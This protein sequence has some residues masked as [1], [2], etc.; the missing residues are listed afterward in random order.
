[1]GNLCCSDRDKNRYTYLVVRNWSLTS[2][3]SY[4][5]RT[6]NVDSSTCRVCHKKITT[7]AVLAKCN[8]CNVAIGHAGCVDTDKECM[9]CLR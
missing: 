3:D 9:L 7:H 6:S 5:I 8:Y 4:E 2:H 1:M